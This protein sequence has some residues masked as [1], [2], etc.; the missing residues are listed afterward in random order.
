MHGVTEFGDAVEDEWLIV[1]ILRRLTQSHHSVWARVFDTD[2][3]FLLVEAANV[4]PKWLS[5]EI[6]HNRVWI[7]LGKLYIVPHNAGTETAPRDL[8]LSKALKFIKT[9]Q[10]DLV[11]SGLLESEA[12]YRLEKYPNQIK[13]ATHHSL[14][15]IPRTL[16]YILHALPKS[17]APAVEAFYLRDD[18]QL[19]PILSSSAPLIFPPEDLVT[20]SVHFSKVLFAQLRSQRF[21]APPRWERVISR[22]RSGAS[23]AGAGDVVVQRVEMG[24]KLTCGFEILAANAENSKNRTAREL[25]ILIEDMK[26]DGDDIL[27]SDAVIKSWPGSNL[28]DSEAWLDIDFE[29]FERELEGRRSGTNKSGKKGFGDSQTQDNLRKIVTRFE[30][31]LNDDKA[32]LDGAELDEMDF[33]DEDDDDVMSS[34][35]LDVDSDG[36]D[37]E[38]SFDEQEFSNMMREMMG[39]PSTATET[40]GIKSTGNKGQSKQI[41]QYNAQSADDKEDAE[42]QEL[43]SQMEA[44][45]NEHGALKLDPPTQSK[46]LQSKGKSRAKSEEDQE[47]AEEGSDQEVDVDYNLAKNLLESFKSQGG[48]AGPTGNILGMMGINLPRDEDESDEDHHTRNGEPSGRR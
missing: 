19:K 2:G 29:D 20:V 44:E 8:S 43:A 26:E 23:D 7:H 33:D 13:E 38:V 11:Y 35:N 31:F 14:V 48:M 34:S 30:A 18:L 40:T 41:E 5:P 12:F 45:L 27:P 1:Y 16:A 28:N 37:R 15:T 22:L 9:C 4:L 46:R 24:M 21:E 10:D 17:V 36:E 47:E 39:M 42:I 3:E 25:A 6:D 32:G